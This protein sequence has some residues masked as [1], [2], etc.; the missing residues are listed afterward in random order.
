ME[1]H[2][3]GEEIS[4]M[5]SDISPLKLLTLPSTRD[6]KNSSAPSTPKFNPS[7]SS[8]VTY[9]LE[10]LLELALCLSCILL[11][12]PEPDLLLIWESLDLDNSMDSLIV[13][14]RST[15]LMDSSDS[16]KDTPSLLWE[17]L[18]TEPFIS[19]D[20]TPENN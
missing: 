16:I 1:L 3:Y 15:N 8:L 4:P 6:S 7:L 12:S 19:E 9:S 20:M 11:I 2:L 13:F 18:P 17:S 10:E 5:S 14:K